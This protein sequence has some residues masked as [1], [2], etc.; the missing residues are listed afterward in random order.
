MRD[1]LLYYYERELAFLRR[2][3]AEFADRYPK[4][5]SRLQL[6]RTKCE[7]PHVE[8]L[9]EGFAFLAARVHLKIDDDF[10]EVSESLLDVVY[11]HYV[12]PM[13]STS[14]V[15]FELDPEQ[16]KLT[17]GLPIRRGSL[18]Y[19][20]PVGGV[21][22]RF[23][24]CYDTT[25]WPVTVAAAQWTTPERLRPAVRAPEAV[26]AL[27]LEL[28]CLP[29][30]RF[31]QLELETLRLHLAG[32]GSLVYPL[33]ELLG[34]NL[35]RVVVRDPD[36][37]ARRVVLGPEALRPVGFGEDEG[38]L[39][40]PRRSFAGY[41][42]LQEYFTFPDK[43]LFF[44]LGGFAE[45]RAAGFGERAEVVFLVSPFERADRRQVLESGV[46]ARTLRLGCTPVVNLFPQVSE[47]VLLTQRR[48]E[49]LLTPDA[50]R[51]STEIFSVDEVVGVTP[52]AREPVRFEPFY[53]HR[54]ASDRATPQQFWQARRRASRWREDEGTD[55]FLAFVD[56]SARTIHPD[57]DAV[58]AR[59]TC[60]D[61]NLPARL[62]F[63]G[64]GGDFELQGG[65]P[66][67]RITALVKPTPVVQPPLGKPQL[68][69]LIS[70]LS[71]NY[72]SLVEEG[73][74]ALQEILRLHNTG[75]DAA[76]EKH[77]QGIVRVSSAPAHARVLGEHGLAFARGRRVELE[78]DEEQFAG[79]SAYLLA[80]V[81]E[82][83]LGLYTSLNSFSALTAR[84][85]QRR[86]PLGEWAP[87]AGGKALL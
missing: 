13:P 79:G 22:C 53:S 36:D 70:Q 69:R 19:S 80:S 68:W 26:A 71:L 73:T 62:P 37:P 67:R 72:L 3:G 52:G 63:G 44:D 12:R 86:R 25:L 10:P 28:R 1:D 6:E 30:V 42:L 8:R 17:T 61:G 18:L 57:L 39:P 34:H 23:R 66:L 59:L 82:R 16:G 2:M 15:E 43:F 27:R 50:R 11:P 33:Y 47:P 85:R 78:L 40:F 56:L 55:V 60:F 76:G 38:I 45:L 54:H 81:L 48:H 35:V 65:G 74:D 14:L 24:T 9:L 83:F 32:D 51:A 87:R 5:A 46:N 75:D 21:P 58:T 7:D 29:D 64:D 41:R 49:Y 77:I 31:D 84:S 20:R 4:V